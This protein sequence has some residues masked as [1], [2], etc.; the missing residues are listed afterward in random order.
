MLP[1]V[2]L[3]SLSFSDGRFEAIASQF[4]EER[5]PAG[6]SIVQVYGDGLK[7]TQGGLAFVYIYTKRPAGDVAV[8]KINAVLQIPDWDWVV[9]S[10]AFIDD[11]DTTFR[12][13]VGWFM[14]IGA[15][16]L[17]GVAGLAVS[18]ARGIYRSIGGEPAYA[19]EIARAIAAG[20]LTR[21]I[22]H[23][24]NRESLV[25]AVVDM[26]DSLKAMIGHIKE[27]ADTLTAAGD[28]LAKQMEQI[29]ASAQRS[30]DATSSTAAA[31]EEMTVSVAQISDNAAESERN[32]LRSSELADAGGK[33][34][35]DAATG[36]NTIA[37][38]VQ[39]ASA[40]I[41]VLAER[42]KEIGGFANVIKDIAD[43]TNLLALNA[44]IEAARAGE[45]GRGF[46]VVADEV[47]KLAERSS[48]TTDQIGSVI[49]AIQNDTAAVVASMEAVTPQVEHGVDVAANAG[50]ALVEI[51]AGAGK[52][53]VNIRDVAH[54]VSE[55]RV[56]SESVAANVE[57]ISQM[58]EEM[59]M[60]VGV[61]NDNVQALEHLAVQ[62]RESVIRFRV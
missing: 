16:L 38:Q 3:N 57:Q 26:Q 25:A 10:G 50:K 54:A 1:K 52:T 5:R 18:L 17:A 61:A 12:R 36:L 21:A 56:A 55:Q 46:A 53:L 45:Q 47:R 22:P 9:G 60:A 34:L 20:D 62:L 24:E 11:I 4:W 49:L 15:L 29:N 23:Q 6:R 59:A 7:Q 43:Q 30:A 32:S 14:A 39:G 31:I 8:P 40:L 35:N 51:N 28:G 37:S 44:A 2:P 27:G 48:T 58:V 33:L 19:T 41:A 13:H 42:S